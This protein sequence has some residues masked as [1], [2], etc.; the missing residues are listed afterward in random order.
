MINGT[1]FAFAAIV[2]RTSE[3][4]SCARMSVSIVAVTP[5]LEISCGA[6][7]MHRSSIDGRDEPLACVGCGAVIVDVLISVK[8]AFR[9]RKAPKA[10][11]LLVVLSP[12]CGPRALKSPTSTQFPPF[13]V[14]TELMCCRNCVAGSSSVAGVAGGRYTAVRVSDMRVV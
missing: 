8:S 5:N 9:V 6:F 10:V 13:S 14:D 1:E 12:N 3:W 11:L 4:F 2:N 7:V